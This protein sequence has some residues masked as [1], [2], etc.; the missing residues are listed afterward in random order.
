MKSGG[1]NIWS[2]DTIS[3]IGIMGIHASARHCTGDWDGDINLIYYGIIG[4]DSSGGEDSPKAEGES[5]HGAAEDGG[6]LD[7]FNITKNM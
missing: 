3:Y 7:R 4:G 1:T 6:G 2:I 5:K